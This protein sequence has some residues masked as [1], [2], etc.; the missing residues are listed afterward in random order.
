MAYHR[1][2]KIKENGKPILLPTE[3]ETNDRKIKVLQRYQK[4]I[5]SNY[6]KKE[7]SEIIT[8]LFGYLIK[9]LPI[10]FIKLVLN[11]LLTIIINSY[12]FNGNPMNFLCKISEF[13]NNYIKKN[14]NI[15]NLKDSIIRNLILQIFYLYN[16]PNKTYNSW[17]Y[18]Y[19]SKD[20]IC[21]DILK[22]G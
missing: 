18:K 6:D 21:K 22:H 11:H 8:K 3:K 5:L 4:L 13:S 7:L 1:Q 19:E 14:L 16:N 2:L 9:I 17:D 15:I 12:K 10:N 20:R